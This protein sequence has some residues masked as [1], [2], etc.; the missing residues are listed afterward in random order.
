MLTSIDGKVRCASIIYMLPYI[1][2]EQAEQSLLRGPSHHCRNLLSSCSTNGFSLQTRGGPTGKRGFDPIKKT[3]LLPASSSHAAPR[4]DDGGGG[5]TYVVAGA[6]VNTRSDGGLRHFGDEHLAE[7]LGRRRAERTKRKRDDKIAEATLSRLLEHDG[8]TG[9]TGA[10]YLAA[11]DKGDM[12]KKKKKTQASEKECEGEEEERRKR[13]FS[14]EAVK[15]IGFDPTSRHV[16]E[17]EDKGKRVSA[18]RYR[19][20]SSN[21][22]KER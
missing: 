21:A 9:S 5:A 11:V 17:G 1:G 14:A 10:K 13:P 22:E 3:G 7:K 6:T 15:R 4:R 20:K 12:G 2:D 8:N 18:S 16:H 19:L